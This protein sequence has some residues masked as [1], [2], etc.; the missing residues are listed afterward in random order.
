MFVEMEKLFNSLLV[1]A[2]T[3]YKRSRLCFQGAMIVPRATSHARDE[4]YSAVLFYQIYSV[5][6]LRKSRFYFW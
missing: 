1:D 5:G 4:L 2:S 6:D 3:K